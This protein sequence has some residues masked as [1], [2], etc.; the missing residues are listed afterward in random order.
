MDSSAPKSTDGQDI[1]HR[2][3]TSADGIVEEAARTLHPAAAVFRD[4]ILGNVGDK[5]KTLEAYNAR[6]RHLGNLIQDIELSFYTASS[7]RG[8]Q[9]N[10]FHIEH[11]ETFNVKHKIGQGNIITTLRGE[12][13]I[14]HRGRTCASRSRLRSNRMRHIVY[15][16]RSIFWI[17]T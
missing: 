16:R 15:G 3:A 6:F 17:I 5:N 11:H 7:R 13:C 12:A 8:E 1:Q 14:A 10:H 9:E 2:Q 4:E